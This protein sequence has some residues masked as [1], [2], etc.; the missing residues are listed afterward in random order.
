MGSLRVRQWEEWSSFYGRLVSTDWGDKHATYAGWCAL[1]LAETERQR[2]PTFTADRVTR[3][4]VLG[5]KGG[6][7]RAHR[8]GDVGEWCLKPWLCWLRSKRWLLSG[9]LKCAFNGQLTSPGLRTDHAEAFSAFLLTR[10]GN[11]CSHCRAGG[12]PLLVCS[13]EFATCIDSSPGRHRMPCCS[14]PCSEP[15]SPL[16]LAACS[17]LCFCRP[18][19]PTPR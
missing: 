10:F 13:I 15:S 17:W 16:S 2:P 3:R 8:Q 6:L 1:G 19:A 4:Q 5:I 11:R 7:N 9:G 14:P 12:A 18:L